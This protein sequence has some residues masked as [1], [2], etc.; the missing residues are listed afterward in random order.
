MRQPG[1]SCRPKSSSWPPGKLIQGYFPP[2]TAAMHPYHSAAR[3]LLSVSTFNRTLSSSPFSW[4]CRRTHATQAAAL[5]PGA[6][7]AVPSPPRIEAPTGAAFAAT[8]VPLAGASATAGGAGGPSTGTTAAATASP[9]VHLRMDALTPGN[10]TMMLSPF[11]QESLV[12][13]DPLL[14]T[15]SLHAAESASR[16]ESLSRGSCGVMVLAPGFDSTAA[17]SR[18]CSGV[19]HLPGSGSYV[20]GST[21]MSDRPLRSAETAYSGGGSVSSTARVV[22][23]GSAFSEGSQQSYGAISVHN[24]GSSLLGNPGS[25]VAGGAGVAV[26]LPSVEPGTAGTATTGQSSAAARLNGIA[27]RNDA[28]RRSESA[29]ERQLSGSEQAPADGRNGRRVAGCRTTESARIHVCFI[30]NSGSSR[31]LLSLCPFPLQRPSAS[32][33]ASLRPP[34]ARGAQAPPQARRSARCPCLHFPRGCRAPLL[35]APL[36]RHRQ[37]AGRAAVVAMRPAAAQEVPAAPVPRLSRFRGLAPG[38][39]GSRQAPLWLLL[40][41]ITSA[42]RTGWGPPAF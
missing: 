37:Q 23:G 4:I 36:T 33:P 12:L 25:G 10:S 7:G 29:R 40:G 13:V 11:A 19:M 5:T 21:A 35:W 26:R 6:P 18:G 30:P 41:A 17:A 39:I 3:R 14:L 31:S 32:C 24:A 8:T 1:G 22:V 20:E 34:S 16:H 9:H 15:S 42:C 38:T 2:F 27:L 28:A